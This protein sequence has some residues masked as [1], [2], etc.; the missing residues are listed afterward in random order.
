MLLLLPKSH[1]TFG[2]IAELWAQEDAGKDDAADRDKILSVFYHALRNGEFDHAELTIWQRV[3]S[4]L[5]D[6]T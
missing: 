5:Q 3:K 1:R 4:V 2:E 6:T